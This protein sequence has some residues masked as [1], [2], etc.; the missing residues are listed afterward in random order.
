VLKDDAA[1]PYREYIARGMSG[2]GIPRG[3]VGRFRG[4]YPDAVRR[5]PA[6][7][8]RACPAMKIADLFVI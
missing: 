5:F 4:G 1:I 7:D 3:F 6:G 8:T 2:R